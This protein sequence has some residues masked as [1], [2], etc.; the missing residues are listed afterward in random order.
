[1]ALTTSGSDVDVATTVTTGDGSHWGSGFFAVSGFMSTGV[2]V[3]AA[4]AASIF[5]SVAQSSVP[6]VSEYLGLLSKEVAGTGT[7]CCNGGSALMVVV[8]VVEVILLSVVE[9]LDTVLVLRRDSLRVPGGSCASYSRPGISGASSRCI[10]VTS[11]FRGPQGERT[12]HR[13]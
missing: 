3:V 7:C 5:V 1:M 2:D 10:R 9:L 4:A 8:L 12:A 6:I 13:S 11:A